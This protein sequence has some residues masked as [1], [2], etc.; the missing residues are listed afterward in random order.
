MLYSTLLTLGPNTFDWSPKVALIMIICNIVAIAFAK[1]T[2]KYP[3]VG[4][5]MPGSKYFGGFGVAG[6]LAT[7]SFGH[8]LGAGVILGLANLG[9]L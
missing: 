3:S 2:V 8:L 5:E 6:L 9:S 4:R 7:T 1:Y